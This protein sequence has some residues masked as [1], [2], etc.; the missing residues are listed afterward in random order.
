MKHLTHYSHKQPAPEQE[1][2]TAPGNYYVTVVDKVSNTGRTARRGFLLGPFKDNH[3]AAL[4]A[5]E[6]VK[7]LA[8]KVDP[9]SHFYQFGT[10]RCPYDVNRPG[11][12]NEKLKHLL[13]K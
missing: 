9:W 8:M 7:A 10:A 11:T 4:A 12:F 1:P 6:E 2:D 13:T 3:K 5:V